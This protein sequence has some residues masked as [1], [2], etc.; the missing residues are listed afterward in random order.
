MGLV[1]AGAEA[2]DIS[3]PFDQCS[4]DLIHI[5]P[6]FCLQSCKYTKTNL[7]RQTVQFRL[8]DLQFHD[9][10]SFILHDAPSKTFICAQAVTLFLYTQNN[11]VQ[12]ESTTM[13]ATDLSHSDLVS[14]A[15]WRFLHLCSHQADPDTTIY[16][17]FL[18]KG[19]L[20]KSVTST[21]IISLFRLHANNIGFRRLGLYPH[22]I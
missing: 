21:H 20:P 9:A 12:G 19:A 2:A 8:M 4:A 15:A 5:S 18:N 1:M 14:A 17:Y 6:F 10:D 7:H 3:C 13:E 11:T 16:S 22:D